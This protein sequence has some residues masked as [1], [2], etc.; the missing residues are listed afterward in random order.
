MKKVVLITITNTIWILIFVFNIVI[1]IGQPILQ[2]I[3][4]YSNN[5]IPLDLMYCVK[6][7]EI[8]ILWTLLLTMVIWIINVI[9]FFMFVKK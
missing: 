1:P 2:H 8:I 9:M 4:D 7:V 3:Q 6:Q 5:L